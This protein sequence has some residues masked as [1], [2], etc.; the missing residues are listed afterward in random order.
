MYYLGGYPGNF[1]PMLP[2]MEIIKEKFV[3]PDLD[4]LAYSHVPVEYIEW[5]REEL[6]NSGVL[7]EGKNRNIWIYKK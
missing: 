7:G 5:L 3:D 2:E 1:L 6:K 4:F